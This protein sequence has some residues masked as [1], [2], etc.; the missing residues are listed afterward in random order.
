MSQRARSWEFFLCGFI[1]GAT[2]RDPE[3]LAIDWTTG[4][5]I[6]ADGTRI[7]GMSRDGVEITILVTSKENSNAER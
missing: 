2:R 6:E 7:R 3:G 5:M 4:M 1:C